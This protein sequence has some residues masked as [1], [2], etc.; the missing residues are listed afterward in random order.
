MIGI[1]QRRYIVSR[2]GASA[3]FGTRVDEIGHILLDHL[4]DKEQRGCSSYYRI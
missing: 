3:V 4:L 1:I 2:K